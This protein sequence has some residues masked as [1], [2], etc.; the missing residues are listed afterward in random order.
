MV[1]PEPTVM[2]LLRYHLHI[3]FSGIFVIGLSFKNLCH[4][5]NL[6]YRRKIC[7]HNS[8]LAVAETLLQQEIAHKEPYRT[9]KHLEI[10]IALPYPFVGIII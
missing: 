5:H 6:I 1:V 9:H 7:L 3:D 2:Y 4:K 10:P 8:T